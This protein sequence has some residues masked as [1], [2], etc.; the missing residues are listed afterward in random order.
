MKTISRVFFY[1]ALGAVLVFWTIFTINNPD[2]I[3]LTF[4]NWQSAELPI[5]V[6]LIVA[7][8][9]GGVVGILLCA[10][11]YLRG[12]A[13]QR[14]LQ[15]ELNETRDMPHSEFSAME[16]VPAPTPTPPDRR[17]RSTDPMV[18]EPG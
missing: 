9:M 18:K 4:L 3:G 16:H 8:V 11:G 14:R 7:F 5:T 12:K 13:T 17:Q 10:S 6:W 2:P 1:I 15:A